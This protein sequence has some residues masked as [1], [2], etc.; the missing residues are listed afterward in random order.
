MHDKP[1]GVVDSWFFFRCF[2]N[3]L[4]FRAKR[5]IPLCSG[6]NTRFLASLGMTGLFHGFWVPLTA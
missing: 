5:G 2:E 4:S 1:P 6:N 3:A